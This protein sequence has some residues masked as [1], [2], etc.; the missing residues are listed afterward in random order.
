MYAMQNKL[1]ESEAE[2]AAYRRVK[3]L[4]KRRVPKDD[5]PRVLLGASGRSV[6]SASRPFH[7]RPWAAWPP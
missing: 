7:C 6:P 3:P 4:E 1:R 5:K 2:L